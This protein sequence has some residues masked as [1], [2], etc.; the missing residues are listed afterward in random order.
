[1]D[2]YSSVTDIRC[3]KAPGVMNISPEPFDWCCSFKCLYTIEAYI[4]QNNQLKSS[5]LA[6]NTSSVLEDLSN[7]SVGIL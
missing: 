4:Q 5:K 2:S 7:M 3:L 6:Y 1:M